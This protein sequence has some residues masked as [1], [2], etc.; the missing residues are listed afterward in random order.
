MQRLPLAFFAL[1][2]GASLFGLGMAWLINLALFGR[3][4][5][6][7][8]QLIAETAAAGI[9]CHNPQQSPL[10][11]NP[12]DQGT[13]AGSLHYVLLD[14]ERHP[15]G[16]RGHIPQDQEAAWQAA[17]NDSWRADN[18]W[19][20][21]S[22]WVQ[23]TPVCGRN[24]SLWGWDPHNETYRR[25]LLPRQIILVVSCSSSIILV[26]LLAF[27]FM[28]RKGYEARQ[29]LAKIRTGALGSRLAQNFWVPRLQLIDEFNRMAA[30]VED[31]FARLQQIEERRASLLSELAHDVRTPLASLRAAAETL[32][33]FHDSISEQQR[34]ALHQTLMLDVVYFQ[35]LIDDLLILAQIDRL[36]TLAPQ[37]S[38]RIS[39]IL[40]AL[41]QRLVDQSPQL[42][43]NLEWPERSPADILVLGDETLVRRLL[44]NTLDN[45][46]HYA[47]SFVRCRVQFH[48]DRLR[49]EISNDAAP[50]SEDELQNWGHK[51]RQRIITEKAGLPHT[52]LGLGSSIIVGVSRHLGGHAQI[53]QI[54]TKSDIWAQIIV[55][56]DLPT[57]NAGP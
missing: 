32:S 53:K 54:H 38:S 34:L 10:F 36:D 30:A 13:L 37:Q 17:R 57:I 5:A 22:I 27:L 21:D 9:D 19:R 3:P 41:W 16:H 20:A 25:L 45:A 4:H 55:F 47:H 18:P 50:L 42:D 44:Q 6:A 26:V 28:R 48:G 8:L 12:S 43:T 1:L 23:V 51:R 39:G 31:S 15:L 29:V 24:W 49:L 33:E 2:G 11:Q 52:S 35:S 56:I 7:L 14:A 40:S 46:F